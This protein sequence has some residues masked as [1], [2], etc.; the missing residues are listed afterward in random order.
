MDLQSLFIFLGE[1][2]FIL[3][4][5]YSFRRAKMS[6]KKG[7]TNCYNVSPH[8]FWGHKETAIIFDLIGFGL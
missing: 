6:L 5:L 7:P 8:G 4:T 3:L 1:S 2:N